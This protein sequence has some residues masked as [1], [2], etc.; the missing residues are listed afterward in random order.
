MAGSLISCLICM[1]SPN[2]FI[3]QLHGVLT[4]LWAAAP[5]GSHL[6][7]HSLVKQWFT[8]TCQ[9]WH[10]HI[11]S[12]SSQPNKWSR[13]SLCLRSRS[14]PVLV[15]SQRGAEINS[16]RLPHGDH[17]K[18]THACPVIGSQTQNWEWTVVGWIRNWTRGKTHERAAH[19]L[20][21]LPATVPLG[22]LPLKQQ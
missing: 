5:A 3:S 21:D 8:E 7:V 19:S 11:Y 16:N 17:V 10:L 4:G 1:A 15:T 18:D 14:H 6:T 2:T 9:Q 12:A 22:K 20:L 13:S